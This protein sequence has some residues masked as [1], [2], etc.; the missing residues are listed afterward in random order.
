MNIGELLQLDY[1]LMFKAQ[2]DNTL[3]LLNGNPD[4]LQLA[5]L[6]PPNSPNANLLGD[7]F[8]GHFQDVVPLLLRKHVFNNTHSR[9]FKR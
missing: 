3:R 6:P 8:R 2:S 9:S 5:F 4:S 1:I 7:I